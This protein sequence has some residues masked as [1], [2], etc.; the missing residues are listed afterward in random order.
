MYIGPESE[1][2]PPGLVSIEDI[3]QEEPQTSSPIHLG[4]I[5][6]YHAHHFSSPHT[7]SQAPLSS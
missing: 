7:T 5:H 6:F 3:P 4:G 1:P 2:L